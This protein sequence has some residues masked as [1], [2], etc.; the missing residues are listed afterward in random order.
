MIQG[1]RKLSAGKFNVRGG[2]LVSL[3]GASAS[4]VS[5]LPAGETDEI[6]V[7]IEPSPDRSPK[8]SATVVLRGKPRANTARLRFPVALKQIGGS[9]ILAT[10]TSEETEDETAGVWFLR[11]ANGMK[12]SLRLSRLPAA[13]WVWEGWGVTQKT[14]LTTGRFTSASGADRSSPFSGPKPGPPFPGEDFLRRLPGGL[15]MP[16]DLA[17]GS[18]MVVLTIEPDLRGTDPTGPAPFSIKPLIA[19]ISAGAAD[20][21]SIRLQRDL[22][23]VP[24]GAVRFEM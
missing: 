4:F 22:S 15:S 2:E 23:G 16:A 5:P 12:P 19:K 18:S 3:N 11:M 14:P 7:T 6:A 21:T 9:F 8:P 17:D 13:G 1:T 10:P 20:H 24:T